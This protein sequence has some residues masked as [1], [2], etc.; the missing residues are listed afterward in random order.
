MRFCLV[1]GLVIKLGVDILLNSVSAQIIPDATLGSEGSRFIEDVEIDRIEG[2]AARGVNLFHS[3]TEFNVLDGQQVYFANPG[4]IENILSRVTGGNGSTILGTLGVLGNANLFLVN[5]NGIVFGPNARLDVAGSFVASTGNGFNFSDGSSFSATNPEAPPLLTMNV[6]PGLQRG[7]QPLAEINNAGNLEV[8]AGQT[9]ALYGGDVNSTGSLSAPGGT[10]MVLGD[11][12]GLLDNAQI[13][14]SSQTGG[15][16]VLIGGELQGKGAVPNATRTFVDAGV[17]IEADALT[18]GDGGTVIVW[19]DEVTGFYGN[20]SARGGSDGGNGGFVEVSGKEHLIFRGGVDTSASQGNP[21]TLLLD[22]EN[23]TIVNGDGVVDDNQ[24]NDSQILQG[25]GSA[26]SFTIAETTLE[27]LSGN[28][29]VILQATNNIT[30]NDLDDNELTFKDGTGGITFTADADK[31]GVGSF[32]MQD[33]T[34]T[35]K[36]NGRNL[37]ISGASLTLGNINTSFVGGSE[38]T[39]KEVN[40]NVDQGGPIPQTGTSGTATFTF[41]VPDQGA[42]VIKDLNVQFSAQHTYDSDLDVSLTSPTGTTINLFSNVGGSG[43]NFQDT[44]L[45]VLSH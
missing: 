11:R 32:L 6:T 45:V 36:T 12:I 8:G 31:N 42:A 7:T 38:S 22:P 28:T 23:I 34:D 33:V 41:T 27:N 30:I 24:L 3:F 21:G 16:T 29:N 25:D 40:I 43:Q 13:N 5:P 17:Q 9:L 37:E 20:I 35:L 10:V 19:A 14:V 15:G 44:L 4:G 26:S 39:P 1:S 2:G 18:T